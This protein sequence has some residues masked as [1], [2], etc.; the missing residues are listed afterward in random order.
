MGLRM[1]NY[2]GLPKNPIFKGKF[3]KKQY[4]FKV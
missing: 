2:E 1:K 4:R 3:T